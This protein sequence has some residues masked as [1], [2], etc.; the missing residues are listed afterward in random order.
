MKIFVATR[1]IAGLPKSLVFVV[2]DSVSATDVMAQTK[3]KFTWS[4]MAVEG[5]CIEVVSTAKDVAE[6]LANDIKEFT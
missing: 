5:A 2:P 1:L 6:V 3:P 4:L